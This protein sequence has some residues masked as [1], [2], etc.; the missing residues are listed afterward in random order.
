MVGPE[1]Q[2]EPHLVGHEPM[3]GQPGPVQGILALL[4]ALLRSISAIAVLD[5]DPQQAA[6][7]AMYYTVLLDSTN[8]RISQTTA[9]ERLGFIRM[10]LGDEDKKLEAKMEELEQFQSAH[11]AISIEDQA[12]A[13]ITAAAAMQRRA[14]DN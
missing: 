13:V 5:Q 3:A 4:D 10:L 14:G 11:N 7:M 8:K 12:R 2:L 6:D 9:S 1:A